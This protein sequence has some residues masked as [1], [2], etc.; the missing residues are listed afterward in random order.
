MFRSI[1][2]N[3]SI[4]INSLGFVNTH[5][6]RFT[7]SHSP[8]INIKPKPPP[9]SDAMLETF[10]LCR[11]CI[12][13]KPRINVN[14]TDPEYHNLARCAIFANKYIDAEGA[15]YEYTDLCRINEMQCGKIAK[16]FV[17]KNK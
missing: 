7:H 13:F 9:L 17:K 15:R 8:H 2:R 16:H 5:W 1:L 14:K 4:I 10:P 12:H 3:P 11:N 6:P